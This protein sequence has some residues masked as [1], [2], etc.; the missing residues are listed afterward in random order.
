MKSSLTGPDLC[1]CLA[2]RRSARYLT[3]FY[4]HHL[5]V[6]GLSASQFST[7]AL[8]EEHPGIYVV[9]LAELMVM[10]R[11]TLL[12]AVKSLRVDGLLLCEPR[13]SKLALEFTLSKAGKKKLLEAKPYWI[14]A[15]TEF[16]KHA[17]KE[18]AANLRADIL[19]VVF[20]G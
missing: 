16:E 14:A 4:D 20:A 5:A 6:S 1:H 19:E 2:A 11:T 15:Q 10:E 12:R 13:G 3:R 8:V 9:A 7:L 18:R 17:G